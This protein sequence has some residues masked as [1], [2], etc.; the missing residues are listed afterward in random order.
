MSEP[1]SDTYQAWL[2]TFEIKNNN[3][4]SRHWIQKQRAHAGS[5][6]LDTKTTCPQ[7]RGPRTVKADTYQAW[8]KTYEIKSNTWIQ[9]QRAHAG[10]RLLDTLRGPRTV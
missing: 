8:L 2:K 6:L 1:K 5:G 10:S 4:G 9:K 7:L 3:I